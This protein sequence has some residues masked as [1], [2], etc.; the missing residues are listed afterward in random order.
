[1]PFKKTVVN[2]N[3]LKTCKQKIEFYENDILKNLFTVN[4][5]KTFE[6]T[7]AKGETL[8]VTV[9][10]LQDVYTILINSFKTSKQ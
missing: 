9:N 6:F 8:K 5:G 7:S 10:S 2:E 3:L 1:M 4:K